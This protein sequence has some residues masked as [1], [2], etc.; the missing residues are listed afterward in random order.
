MVDS[1]SGLENSVAKKGI[2]VSTVQFGII[3]ISRMFENRADLAYDREL[4]SFYSS[5]RLDL[6]YVRCFD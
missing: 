1:H 3:K 4:P 6:V 2:T 5:A